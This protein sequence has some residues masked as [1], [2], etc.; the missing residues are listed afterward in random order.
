MRFKKVRDMRLTVPDGAKYTLTSIKWDVE[1]L[2]I[3]LQQMLARCRLGANDLIRAWDSTG[4]KKINYKE[5][6]AKIRGFF[7]GAVAVEHVWEEEVEEVADKA[8]YSIIQSRTNKQI[9]IVDLEKW[10]D[11]PTERPAGRKIYLKPPCAIKRQETKILRIQQEREAMQQQQPKRVDTMART[12]AAIASAAAAAAARETAAKDALVERVERWT[13]S[14]STQVNGQRWDRPPLQRWEVPKPL[15]KPTPHLGPTTIT[16]ASADLWRGDVTRPLTHLQPFERRT[17]SSPTLAMKRTASF[18]AVASHSDAGQSK[19]F[20]S[21]SS[22]SSSPTH[23][24]KNLNRSK[25]DADFRSQVA[26]LAPFDGAVP[27]RKQPGQSI[28]YLM[29]GGTAFLFQSS[30][31]PPPLDPVPHHSPVGARVATPLDLISGAL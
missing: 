7:K 27:P 15:E 20:N 4:D 31:G 26:R 8:F 24:L 22:A 6:M 14:H 17:I 28:R 3:L 11:A 30:L 23:V 18:V 12:R 5:F 21:N 19:P 13:Q 2:R 29:P 1:T 10:L 25:S 9:N 16:K